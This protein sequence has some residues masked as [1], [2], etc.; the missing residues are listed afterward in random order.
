M[1][2]VSDNLVVPENSV[3]VKEG[4]VGLKGVTTL[5][6]G[7]AYVRDVEQLVEF[8]AAESLQFEYYSTEDINL[9]IK[10]YTTT[11]K[12]YTANKAMT[13][14]DNWQREQLPMSLFKDSDLKK[15]TTWENVWRITFLGLD[16]ALINKLL[17]V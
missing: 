2:P 7:L 11:G 13:P 15:L 1:L 12:V 10:L 4:A 16:G 8:V 17:L 3:V 6:E 9:T 5:T 14:D